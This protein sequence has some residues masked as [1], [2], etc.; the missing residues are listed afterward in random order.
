MTITLTQQLL[1]AL[2]NPEANRALL[3]LII[4]HLLDQPI[5]GLIDLDAL[6]KSA[7]E[8]YQP[9]VVKEIIRALNP[10]E[11]KR[12]RSSVSEL[13]HPLNSWL[14]PELDA[15]LRALL[16]RGARL[17]TQWALKVA[18]HPLTHHITRAFVEE[19]LER[20]IQR[21]KTGLE[22]GG[23]L[24][25]ASRG[26]LGWA[27]KASRGV[28][29][30]LGEQIQGQLR[31]ITSDFISASMT[32]LLDQLAHI[33][34]SPEVSQQLTRALLT[35]YED[36]SARPIA[37]VFQPLLNRE[38][39]LSEE[40]LSEWSE[41]LADWGAHCLA[42]PDLTRWVEALQTRLLE[43][44]GDQTTRQLINDHDTTLALRSSLVELLT[45]HAL[46]FVTSDRLEEWCTTYL[47]PDQ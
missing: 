5:S 37:E 33:V 23:L 44:L 18:H 10:S 7:R 14:T 45:P 30:G 28:R 17:N 20:F 22:G 16:M 42:H 2:N 34:T 21:A 8:S 11:L 32:T 27:Q 47:S 9:E 6:L 4:D 12:W 15:E 38:S 41:L 3:E 43:E 25:V 19:T 46:K 29:G 13:S 36:L 39:P 26:A 24:G 35:G 40:Q 31:G 1:Q